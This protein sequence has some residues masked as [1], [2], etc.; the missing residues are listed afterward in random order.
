[1]DNQD[2]ES[3]VGALFKGMNE[4]VTS[5]TVVGEP[6]HV[7]DTIIVPLVDVTFGM[8]AGAG[9]D[10]AKNPNA[11]GGMG[12]KVT[13]NAMLV[14]SGGTTKLVS[15]KGGQDGLSKILDMVPDF[16][17]KFTGKSKTEAVP[18]VPVTEPEKT[19]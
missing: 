18:E 19:E 4:F 15:T 7:G 16:V 8:G 13:P 10:S 1:M 6:I 3:T 14:I 5:K 12:G 17:N 2:F 9:K 11:G